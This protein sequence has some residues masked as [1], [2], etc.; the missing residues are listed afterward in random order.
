MA[1]RL[2]LCLLALL[3][4]APAVAECRFDAFGTIVNP[5]DPDCGGQLFRYTRADDSGF[6]V[7]LGYEVP[8]PVDS[9][10]PV[11]GF[12]SYQSLFER[13]QALDAE[14]AAV[15]GT[16]VGRTLA[17]RAIWAYRVGD[18]DDVTVDGGAEPMAL[19]NGTIH[20]REWQSPEAVTGLF[21]RLVD[22]QNDRGIGSYLRDNLN[23]VVLPV[24]NID[25]FLTTQKYPD[26]FTASEVQPREG[27]QRRKNG[28]NPSTG[29]AIDDDI[30]TIDDNF[31]GVD[32]NRNSPRGWGQNNGSTQDPVSLVNR[33]PTPQSEPEIEALV[34]ATR[35]LGSAARL[36]FYTD[37]HSYSQIYFTPMTGNARRDAITERLVGRMRAVLNFKYRYGPDSSSGIGLTSDYFARSF[38]VPAWTLETE[39]LQG[40]IDY[41]GTGHGHSGFILPASEVDRMRDEVFQ[42]L[43]AGIYRQAEPPRLQAVEIR[44]AVSG[45]LRYAA[46]WQ[47]G[48]ED[49]RRR[50]GT[51][52]A[53]VPG[54][55]YRLWLAFNKPM[56]WRDPGGTITNYR[57]Q[58]VPLTPRI[59]LEF[60]TLGD[61]SLDVRPTGVTWLDRTGG[62]AAEGYRRYRDDALLA[63]FEI[64]AGLDPG[65]AAPAVLSV[66]AQDMIGAA[67]DGD[68]ATRVD[69]SG[70]H[71]TGY[72]D[73]DGNAGDSGGSDC[74]FI[75]FVA[76]DPAAASPAGRNRTPCRAASEA[77]SGG[78]GGGSSGDGSNG[79]GSGGGGA[80]L[81]LLL[82]VVTL[83]LVGTTA[84]G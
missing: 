70:G 27:R 2:T 63:E 20:A 24:L 59:R 79:G 37:V 84:R 61:A 60:P 62:A 35:E 25:G 42:M 10:T 31:W 33:G 9:L 45:E 80:A 57:G 16:P 72:E 3:P 17:G 15:A 5:R 75:A 18:T 49:R 26:R 22:M 64:P 8:R 40:G 50:L 66:S 44:D 81:W 74:K 12:R 41:G 47:A 51:D 43:L 4:A 30:A 58:N 83:R 55:S 21:E 48:A 77:P 69:W 13:H 71:W 7:A 6:N 32:L 53:L 67:L 14:H 36:R 39:P 34:A 1:A 73:V 46:R 68:P 28:R 11:D 23:V 38:Q 65:A 19:I 56:R 82:A 52:L 54:R 29:G 78:A 76:S